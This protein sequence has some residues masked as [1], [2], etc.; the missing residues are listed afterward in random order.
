MVLPN[1]AGPQ[2]AGGLTRGLAQLGL[3]GPGLAWLA[4]SSRAEHSNRS[5]PHGYGSGYGS[6]RVRVYLRSA[7]KC[8]LLSASVSLMCSPSHDSSFSCCRGQCTLLTVTDLHCWT[9]VSSFGIL[10]S[11]SHG[12]G[13]TLSHQKQDMMN[14]VLVSLL[15]PALTTAIFN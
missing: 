15:Q 11:C 3:F 10:G 9:F 8:N 12:F 1:R 13:Q 5:Y 7:L 14:Y 4:A 6:R 2:A